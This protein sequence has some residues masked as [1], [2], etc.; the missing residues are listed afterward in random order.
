MAECEENT[1]FFPICNGVWGRDYM[2]ISADERVYNFLYYFKRNLLINQIF[3][4]DRARFE[5]W[6]NGIT[7]DNTSSLVARLVRGNNEVREVYF[8][9]RAVDSGEN[10]DKISLELIDVEKVCGHYSDQADV[11]MRI[12]AYLEHLEGCQFEYD[13]ENKGLRLFRY[14]SGEEKNET[15]KALLD[16]MPV[17][18]ERFGRMTSKPDYIHEVIQGKDKESYSVDGACIYKHFELETIYG[19]IRRNNQRADDIKELASMDKTDSFTGLWNK[20]GS[21]EYLQEALKDPEVKQV[22]VFMMDL[23]NFKNVNDIYGHAFGDEVILRMSRIIK[24]VVKD[25]GIGARFGGD[26]YMVVFK[27]LGPE[28]AIRAAAESIRTQIA[29]AFADDELT[30]RISCT[31]GI[32]EYPRNGADFDTIFK[33]ADRA[34]YIGKQKGKNRYIIYKEAIHG[35]LTQ[36]TEVS[37]EQ[38]IR[39]SLNVGELLDATTECINLLSEGGKD[40]IAKVAE[41]LLPLYEKERLSIY[42]GE[43]LKLYGWYGMKEKPPEDL[44]GFKKPEA[45]G[46]LDKYGICQITFHFAQLSYIEEIHGVLRRNGIY[47][48]SI[49]ALTDKNGIKA[50]VCYERLSSRDDAVSRK[51]S[52]EELHFLTLVSRIIAETVLK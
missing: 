17:L 10:R 38:G 26:E 22:V 52:D 9:G 19:R 11:M 5:E 27:N 32:S 43:D 42:T 48:D 31:I 18:S 44:S 4:D 14:V 37:L 49:F 50:L 13:A 30:E 29:W 36:D 47:E 40:S 8:R 1:D 45:A 33:K 16:L 15:D 35:E 23:D 34:L 28:T 25:R 6:W 51:W 12:T 24:S 41:R 46:M 3:E 7:A 39:D 21:L 2:W 20:V